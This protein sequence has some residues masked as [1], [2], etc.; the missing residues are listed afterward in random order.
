[1]TPLDTRDFPRRPSTEL[2]EVIQS[3]GRVL[4]ERASAG[5]AEPA[6]PFEGDDVTNAARAAAL[7]DLSVSS[8]TRAAQE[9]VPWAKQP[10]GFGSPWIISKSLLLAAF[11]RRA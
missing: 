10:G 7:V 3:A 8:I 11:G 9:G 5:E 1:M 2:W 4:A 6:K